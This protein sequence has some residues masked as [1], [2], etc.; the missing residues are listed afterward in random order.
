MLVCSHLSFGISHVSSYKHPIVW[1]CFIIFQRDQRIIVQWHFLSHVWISYGNGFSIYCLYYWTN[2][3]FFSI[4]IQ[5]IFYNRLPKD[6]LLNLNKSFVSLFWFFVLNVLFYLFEN[7]VRKWLTSKE[8]PFLVSLNLLQRI[9]EY[10]IA[11]VR[12][13]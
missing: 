11:T 3:S 1:K 9:Y 10:K 2:I 7:E 13:P 6:P 4:A 5:L 8:T 12:V